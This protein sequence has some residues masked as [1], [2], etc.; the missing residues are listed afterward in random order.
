MLL[1]D[2]SEEFHRS[3]EFCTVR[4]EIS[5]ISITLT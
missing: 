4:Y 3:V 2:Y 5:P 1:I